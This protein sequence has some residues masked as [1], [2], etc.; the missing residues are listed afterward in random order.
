MADKLHN[1][2]P[3][4]VLQCNKA[5][6]KQLL[7]ELRH[8]HIL[9][10]AEAEEIDEG[11]TLRADKCR[12]LVDTVIKKGDKSSNVLLEKIKEK[13]PKLS[14]D[15]GITDPPELPLPKK[16]QSIQQASVEPPLPKK[17][18]FGQQE[19]NGITLCTESEYEEITKLSKESERYPILE[20]GRRKRLALIICNINFQDSKI[21]KREGANCDIEGMKKILKGLDYNVQLSTDLTAEEMQTTMKTFAAHS[22][23]KDSDS[24]FL[25]F[26]SHGERDIIYGTDFKS[27]DVEGRERA[28]GRI[29]VDDIFNTFNNENCPGLRNKPK[30]IIIQ[31]CRGHKKGQVWVSDNGQESPSI[32]QE[33]LE[34]DAMRMIQKESDLICFYSTTPDTVSY[35][36]VNQGSL[37]IQRLIGF[38]KREAHNSSVGDIFQKVQLSFKDDIQ[39][40]T[41][42]RNTLLKK[43]FL[44]P[45]Y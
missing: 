14:E 13:D 19:V 11:N 24:T 34:D 10:D 1:I 26:M 32:K 2:R 15:L 7:D 27:E 35:R 4:F 6:F 41:Q 18:K 37:F 38:I 33:D 5:V 16:E 29:H 40:P 21:G 25:V 20:K 42:D 22:H 9:S 23:H 45:G 8:A 28:T 3:R 12:A 30:V 39:M 17:E 31:A 44:L 36:H 43:F